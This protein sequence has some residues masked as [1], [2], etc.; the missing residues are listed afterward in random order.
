LVAAAFLTHSQAK[1]VPARSLVQDSG[2]P[3]C[4]ARQR[5]IRVGGTPGP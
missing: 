2:A 1:D 4:S 3:A 5:A